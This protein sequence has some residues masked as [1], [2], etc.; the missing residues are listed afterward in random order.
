MSNESMV[1]HA[2]DRAQFL[3]NFLEFHHARSL[4][5]IEWD[6][7]VA[8]LKANPRT[9]AQ[10]EREA[11]IEKMQQTGRP[12]ALKRMWIDQPSTL[13]PLHSLHGTNVLA[14]PDTDKV[15][16]VYF[17]SGDVISQQVPNEAL[18]PGWNT[19]HQPQECED[20]LDLDA[21]AKRFQYEHRNACYPDATEF[22]AREAAEQI[23]RAALTT[24]APAVSRD[25]LVR[26]HKSVSS[27]IDRIAAILSRLRGEGE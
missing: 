27:R 19:R 14:Q 3:Q 23:V 11:V 13:Q 22:E 5:A 24:P 1:T 18:S 4:R 6:A 16:R 20:V 25:E 9:A 12:M 15:M 17:L 8:F 10:P 26:L 2:D 7:I 21:A